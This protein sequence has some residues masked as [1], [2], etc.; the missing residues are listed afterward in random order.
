[1]SVERVQIESSCAIADQ[2]PE[3]I[4]GPKLGRLTVGLL[5]TIVAGAFEALAVAT[6][7]P[8][9]VDDLGGFDY[10]GWILASFTL[11]NLIGIVVA[12]TEIDRQ[13]MVPPF[14]LGIG[15]FRGRVADRW[16]GAVDAGADRWTAGTGI[17]QRRA[18]SRS[19]MRQCEPR[20]MPMCDR[21]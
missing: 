2:S 11:A 5:I 6:V 16:P 17:R 15:L 10:Y 12:G 1:M 9:T 18:R 20:T 4:W 3:S 7:L 19:R 8:Q 13:G 21:G 14:L